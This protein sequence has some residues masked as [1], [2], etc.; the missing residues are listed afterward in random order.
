MQLAK[1]DMPLGAGCKGNRVPR[2]KMPRSK[3]V[4][5][6]EMETATEIHGN[7]QTIINSNKSS[8]KCLTPDIECA[9]R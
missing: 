9:V 3:Q 7:T 5:T 6:D 2:K 8:C 1:H 4:L